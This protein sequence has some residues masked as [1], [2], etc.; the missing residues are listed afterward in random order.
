[1]AR[2]HQMGAIDLDEAAEDGE[3]FCREK[4]DQML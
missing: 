3:E 2:F 4:A 1:M